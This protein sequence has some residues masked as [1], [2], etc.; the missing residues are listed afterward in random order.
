M[1]QRPRNPE[2]APINQPPHR[3]LRN[4]QRQRRLPH[5]ERESLPREVLNQ[6]YGLCGSLVWFSAAR[7]GNSDTL[8]CLLNRL[9]RFV[10]SSLERTILESSTYRMRTRNH[11]DRIHGP[12]RGFGPSQRC[13]WYTESLR[14]S[15]V[16]D[17]ARGQQ[18]PVVSGSMSPRIHG[19]G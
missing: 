3:L 19:E 11:R 4:S 10:A 6:R 5:A 7:R 2:K 1:A 18:Q 17:S 13:T 12:I 9:I 8:P 15:W 14:N 16:P